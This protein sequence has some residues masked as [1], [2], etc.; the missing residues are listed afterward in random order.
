MNAMHGGKAKHDT[1]DSQKLATLLRGGMLP[2]ASVYP[3]AMRAPRDWL[4]RRTPLRRTRAALLAHVHNT[5]AP[6]HWPAI[7]K[8][9]ASR[10]NRAGVAARFDAPA[11]PKTIEVDLDLITYYDQRLSDLELFILKTAKPHDAH[12]LYFLQTV[13]GLGTILRLVWLYAMHQ[14]ARFPR[15][16]DFASYGRL[17]QCAKKSGGKRLGT[18]GNKIGHAPLTWAFSEA[19]TLFLRGNEPGQKYLARLE[20]KHDK[21]TALRILAHQL[22]TCGLL[23]AQTKNSL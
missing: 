4:R 7:G 19:A 21:G 12:T 6:Y 9:S 10:A 13:S 16:Q 17:V 8:K 14:S 2:Q 20:Q 15:V 3:A 11:V 18:V 1:I 23:H 22:A 5:H